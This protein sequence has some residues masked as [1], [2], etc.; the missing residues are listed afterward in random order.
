MGRE[1]VEKTG[2]RNGGAE[3]I[4]TCGEWEQGKA[5]DKLREEKA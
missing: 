2:R 4:F 3:E 5:S 1:N